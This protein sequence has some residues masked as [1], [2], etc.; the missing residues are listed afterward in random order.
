[1]VTESNKYEFEK[2]SNYLA[3]R[4]Y[5][6]DTTAK[7]EWK[8]LENTKPEVDQISR[9]LKEKNYQV[10]E[11]TGINGN[12]E[13]F[14]SL[15]GKKVGIIHIA[16]HGYFQSVEESKK[17]PFILQR[18]GDQ[19][20][21]GATVDPMLRSGLIMTGGNK[22]W[23]CK[24]IPENIEDGVLMAKEISHVDLRGTDLVVLSACETGLGEVSSEGVFGLQRSFKQ[25][26]V[27]SLVMSLWDVND[28]ATRFMMTEFYSNLLSGKDKRAAFLEAKRKCKKEYKYPQYWAAFIM[29]D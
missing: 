17:T 19:Q 8:F 7:S 11:Y 2:S 12:E 15:S 29:L 6:N 13:S 23:L 18:M 25:A 3:R 1:M 10:T 14:K 4:G 5:Q 27:Q 24:K 21:E 16:T 26:G 22:A 20:Q 28:D 9:L